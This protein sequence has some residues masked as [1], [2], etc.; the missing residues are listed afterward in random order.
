ML[1]MLLQ[2][3][4]MSQVDAT[5]CLSLDVAPSCAAKIAMV[6]KV[7]TKI[8]TGFPQPPVLLDRHFL[9]AKS[10]VSSSL[11]T[12]RTQSQQM[13]DASALRSL[14]GTKWRLFLEGPDQIKTSPLILI[15]QGFAEQPNK[16]VVQLSSTE[17]TQ[18]TTGRWISK[19]SEIRKGAVQL[20]ARWKAKVPGESSAYIFKGFIRAATT[21]SAGG[22]NVD[23]QMMGTI[24][25]AETE[26]LVGKFH[27]DLINT[28]VGDNELSM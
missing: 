22:S 20:S 1:H 2:T 11:P 7:T 24:L 21:Y 27:A 23:A 3:F 4:A 18:A 13:S 5:Y 28:N 15:F 26:E 9:L 16:G 17:S 25:A 12:P 6:P 19:P 8:S 14:Q 10:Q